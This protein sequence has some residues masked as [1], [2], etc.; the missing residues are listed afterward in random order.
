MTIDEAG[1]RPDIASWS[2]VAAA[3]VS[4]LIDFA[5]RQAL[6]HSLR[7]R[8][9]ALNSWQLKAPRLAL[10]LPTVRGRL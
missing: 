8:A 2:M 4:G 1:S 6:G 10:P 5:Y 7:D 9:R 3:P